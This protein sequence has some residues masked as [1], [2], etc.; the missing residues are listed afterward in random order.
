M[1][2]STS[3]AAITLSNGPCQGRKVYLSGALRIGRH[4]Y[5]GMSV[6]DLSVSRYHCW[7]KLK[8]GTCTVE[9]LA[10]S[11]GTFVNGARV[12]TNRKLRSGDHVRFGMTEFVYEAA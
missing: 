6:P 10:S 3:E 5:N 8:D 9:D 12:W 4:P 2:A 7:V 11:N 1:V